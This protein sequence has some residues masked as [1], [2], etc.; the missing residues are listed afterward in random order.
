M[1]LKS[2]GREYAILPSEEVSEGAQP[3]VG[4]RRRRDL[5]W[6][7][8]ARYGALYLIVGS[9]IFLNVVQFISWL[10]GSKTAILGDRSVTKYGM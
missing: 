7:S 3:V 10:S 9:S 2:D 6:Q 5:R 8:R 1:F 4:L